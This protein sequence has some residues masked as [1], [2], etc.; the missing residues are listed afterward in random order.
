MKYT[1]NE[2][3]DNYRQFEEYSA[4]EEALLDAPVLIFEMIKMV[5]ELKS[6]GV[7]VC[8][9]FPGQQNMT[10][11]FKQRFGGMGEVPKIIRNL[12]RFKDLWDGTFNV[13]DKLFLNDLKLN[14]AA[15]V[16][17]CDGMQLHH[18]V[19]R[20]DG[21]FNAD[22]Q[23]SKNKFDCYFENVKMDTFNLVLVTMT[24]NHCFPLR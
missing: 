17:N 22:D 11:F 21:P 3:I 10:R 14:F 5:K 9:H 2:Y 15:P 12:H 16:N 6:Y 13:F 18:G 4:Q 24:G 1:T 20:S 19:K 8:W 7:D 23:M